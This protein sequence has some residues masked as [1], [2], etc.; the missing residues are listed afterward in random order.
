MRA[1][2]P[3]PRF[4]DA[5]GSADEQIEFALMQLSVGRPVVLMDDSTPDREGDLMFAAEK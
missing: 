2:A 1:R 5:Y 3:H 4:V